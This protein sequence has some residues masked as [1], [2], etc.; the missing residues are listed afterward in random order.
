M[1]KCKIFFSYTLRDCELNVE[2]L[3]ELK[4]K[5]EQ[6]KGVTTYFDIIDNTAID[7]QKK[8]YEEL[9]ASDLVCLLKTKGIES[10]SWVGKELE[11]AREKKMKI[12]EMD[13]KDINLILCDKSKEELEK[14]LKEKKLLCYNA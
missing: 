13:T 5:I 2:I 10:S 6:I 9:V 3:T 7:H 4:E 1:Y 12:V 8:V 11:I 14:I